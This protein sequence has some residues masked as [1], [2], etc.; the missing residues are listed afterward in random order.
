MLP[1]LLLLLTA[2]AETLPGIPLTFDVV[3]G[4]WVLPPTSPRPSPT[5]GPRPAGRSSP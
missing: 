5:P 3:D 2:R 1:A 4:D